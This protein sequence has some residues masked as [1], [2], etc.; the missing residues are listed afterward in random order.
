VID[1]AL[2]EGDHVRELPGLGPDFSKKTLAAETQ[3]FRIP[4]LPMRSFLKILSNHVEDFSESSAT[5][6]HIFQN[7]PLR[8]RFFSKILSLRPRLFRNL[9]AGSV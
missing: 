6:Q 7:L 3:I 4:Q 8:D 9:W 2:G 1:P 5:D